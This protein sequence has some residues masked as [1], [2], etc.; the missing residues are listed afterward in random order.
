MTGCRED[1]AASA[2]DE[3]PYFMPH[4]GDQLY[5][6]FHRT[7]AEEPA[8]ARAIVVCPPYPWEY[9]GCDRMFVVLGRKLAAAGTHVLRLD[10]RGWR[11]SSGD[12]A[13]ASVRSQVAD[14]ARAVSELQ[15]LAGCPTVGLLGARTG[16]TLAMLA[17]Q[18]LPQV[19]LLVLWDPI[20]KGQ[21]YFD[22][23]LRVAV[24]SARGG[25]PSATPSR[26]QLTRALEEGACVDIAGYPLGPR[27]YQE[28]IQTDL[29]QLQ[30]MRP[31]QTLILHSGPQEP[32]PTD[33][34]RTL[35]DACAG[36]HDASRFVWV[37]EPPYWAGA[38]EFAVAD[39]RPQLMSE[40][41]SWLQN[42]AHP[43]RG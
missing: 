18:E 25:A 22:H 21:A 15:R 8:A 5:C 43:P 24:A 26:A 4:E 36:V 41:L 38:G 10:Y 6:F 13:V 16:A 40:T 20:I 7:L 31:L 11:E 12:P 23:C 28:G 35:A 14:I 19:N 33:A 32:R 37:Q 34:V 1:C 29:T 17:A 27:V 2:E 3:R 9:Q 30:P 42:L 39:D